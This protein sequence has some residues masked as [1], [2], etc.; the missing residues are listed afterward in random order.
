[1]NPRRVDTP[2]GIISCPLHS[3]RWHTMICRAAYTG[4]GI[5]ACPVD[6]YR[7]HAR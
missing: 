4:L 7:T 2:R 3:S 6:S 1:M 5:I